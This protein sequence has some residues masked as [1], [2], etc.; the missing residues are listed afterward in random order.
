MNY[1]K[2]FNTLG[3]VLGIEAALML[4]PLITA[5]VY[6][7]DPAPFLITMALL[8]LVCFAL[9]RIRVIR[10]ELF[11]IE[12]LVTVALAW[13]LMALFGAIPFVISGDIPH[14]VDALFETVSGLTTTGASV[15][16][17]VESMSRSCLFWRMFTHF[18]GGQGVLVFMMAVLPGSG[19]HSMHIMRAEVPGP[20]VG[21]LVPRAKDTAKILYIIYSSMVVA[22][23]VFLML[24]GMSF[25]DA[26]LHA[27]ATAG[28]G[29]FSTRNAS[30]AG[31]NSVYIEMVIAVF[32]VLFGTNFNLYYLIIRGNWK[33][34]LKSEEFHVYLGIIAVATVA[35][36]IS[37]GFRY[38]FFN[39]ASIITTAGF[40]T[41]DFT[42]WPQYTQCIL[43]LL[44]FCGASAG[45]TGGGI[46][47][48]R[49]MILIKDAIAETVRTASP[50]RVKRVTMDGKTVD[51]KV[52]NSVRVFFFIYIAVILLCTFII[53]FDGFDFTT[54]FTA[55]LSCIS[56]IGP[57]LSL[58]GPAG[59]FAIF[60]YPVK[61]V[62]LLTMLTGR[63]E[64][65]PILVLLYPRL[66]KKN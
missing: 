26:I 27:F 55:A 10:T 28:T 31:F 48:S 14:Y 38:S 54:S 51:D 47:I 24:G 1:R 45:S 29:G 3:A 2:I 53:S 16:L 18:I 4:F 12:G 41:A 7:E 17:D 21:K 44:M 40:G 15:C 30:I 63:L 65:Y 32:L 62:M 46:K 37:V 64:L 43:V 34:A 42:Q 25:Y 20:V 57:G 33:T 23:T 22:E 36:G 61:I 8:T 66:W 52:V 6:H 60:S 50:R 13:S 19:E 9:T 59:S 58:I 39:V 11:A 49:I 56:N 35:I 5:F